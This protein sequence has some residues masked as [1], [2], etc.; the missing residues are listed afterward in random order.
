MRG[1]DRPGMPAAAGW[2]VL[3]L[4]FVDEVLAVVALGYVLGGVAA[5]VGV[6][7]WW[8]FASPRA[9]WG[10]AVTRPVVK[11]LVFGAACAAL[12]W[13]GHPLLAVVLL[14]F[15]VAVNLL[16]TMPGVRDLVPTR[17]G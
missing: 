8:A 15:S 4:V 2:T 5:V 1:R 16:A 9:P 3:A 6:A 13:E 11:V 7:L 10:G 14:V 17:A 12:W